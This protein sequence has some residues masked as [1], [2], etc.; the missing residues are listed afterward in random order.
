MVVAPTLIPSLRSSPCIRTH[1]H[2]GFSSQPE[3]EPPDIGTDLWT[4][5]PSHSAIRALAAY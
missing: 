2:L 4:A 1:P 5:R 3:N